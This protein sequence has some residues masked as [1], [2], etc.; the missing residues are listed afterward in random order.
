[1]WR[2]APRRRSWRSAL[3]DVVEDFADEVWI[4]DIGDD[5][6][7]SAAERAEG[8]IDFEDPFEALRAGQGCRK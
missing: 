1:M 7:L 4:G 5:A 2:G 8:D 6:Q 3:L